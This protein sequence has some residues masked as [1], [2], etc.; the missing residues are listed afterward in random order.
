MR[1]LLL[2]MFTFFLSGCA[3]QHVL[4]TGEETSVIEFSKRMRIDMSSKLDKLITRLRGT[5][6]ESDGYRE[7]TT[8]FFPIEGNAPGI[9]YSW[10]SFCES[11][12]G[13]YAN[14]SCEDTT[15]KVLFYS[16]LW[17]TGVYGSGY[18][19]FRIYVIEPTTD[20][21]NFLT[22]AKKQ[23]YKTR[24]EVARAETNR[25][26][27]KENQQIAQRLQEQ[28]RERQKIYNHEAIIRSGVGSKVCHDNP[29]Q[30]HVYIGYVER[31]EN[32]RV[33]IS[34][35]FAHLRGAP[36]ISPGGFRSHE[37]WA[38]QPHDWAICY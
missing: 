11:I 27:E 31:I 20:Y 12:H 15:G 17:E 14:G 1:I 35:Q 6:T 19:Q 5:T 25:L 13:T 8:T 26:R 24:T 36:S 34:V 2:A 18:P 7:Y 21:N 32:N 4:A 16:K 37:I 28:E 23:G 33:K 10:N 9:R 38:Q 3:Q 30:Q 22:A 29:R